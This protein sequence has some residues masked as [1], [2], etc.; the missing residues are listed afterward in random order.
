MPDI[1][2]LEKIDEAIANIY[3]VEGHDV[4]MLLGEDMR[5]ASLLIEQDDYSK[6]TQ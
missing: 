5:L 6:L 3:K 1:D 2:K 4:E